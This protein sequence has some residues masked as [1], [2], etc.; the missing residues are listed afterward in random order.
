MRFSYFSVKLSLQS[1][2]YVSYVTIFRAS[3]NFVQLAIEKNSNYRKQT[4]Y[5]LKKKSLP[6]EA[7]F[8]TTNK[9]RQFLLQKAVAFLLQSQRSSIK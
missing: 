1:T 6:S 8:I 7:Y 4:Y 2:F 5:K 9:V 3:A